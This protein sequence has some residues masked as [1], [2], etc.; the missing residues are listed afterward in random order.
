MAVREKRIGDVAIVKV[1]GILTGG[2]ETK[3]VQ[4]NVKRLLSDGIRKIV[5]DM[6]KVGWMNSHGMGMLMACYSSVRH[7][8]GRIAISGVTDKVE[9]VL[10]ITR[11]DTLFD[12]FSSVD[13][14]VSSFSG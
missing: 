2:D 12:Q 5:L 7:V 1:R 3:E 4:E 9:N 13:Q 6:S 8:G 14:A 11:I 10:K